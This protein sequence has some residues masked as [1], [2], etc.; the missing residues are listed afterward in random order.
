MLITD[1]RSALDRLPTIE[2]DSDKRQVARA[3]GTYEAMP[4][5]SSAF[6]AHRRDKALLSA[7]SGEDERGE[8]RGV[9][10]AKTSIKMG[11]CEHQQSLANNTPDRKRTDDKV[12]SNHM[13]L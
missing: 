12:R 3:T 4:D 7:N 13:V 1:E 6:A 2:P 9:K 5:T 11:K 10:G 8:S